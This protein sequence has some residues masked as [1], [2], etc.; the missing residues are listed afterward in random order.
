MSKELIPDI[1]AMLK[2]NLPPETVLSEDWNS[3]HSFLKNRE[4]LLNENELYLVDFETLIEENVY[5]MKMSELFKYKSNF[6]K[7]KCVW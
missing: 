2:E 3:G 7:I 4:K 1:M 6:T 5:R